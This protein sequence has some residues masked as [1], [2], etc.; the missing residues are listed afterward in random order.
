MQSPSLFISYSHEDEALLKEFT[1]HLSPLVNNQIITAWHDRE[2]VVGDSLDDELRSRLESA[3]LVAFLV[4]SSFLQS[5][6]CYQNE[7]LKVLIRRRTERVEILPIIL[8]DCLWKATP[9][10]QFVAA[11]TDGRPVTASPDRDA[12]WVDVVQQVQVR[13]DRWK[14]ATLMAPRTAADAAKH[15]LRAD[16]QEWLTRT[17]VPFQHKMKQS[18][19]L[20][21]LYVYPDLRGDDV[22]P[23]V[24]FETINSA[25][26]MKPEFVGDG[27]VIHG[28]E[29]AGKTSLIKRL[30]SHYKSQQF[31]PL[32]ADA[33]S[34][35]SSDLQRALHRSVSEQ[36]HELRWDDYVEQQGARILFIDNYDRLRLNVR[37]EKRFLLEA[38]R[39][40]AHLLLVGDSCLTFDEKR[41]VE[42][43]PFRRWE[44]LPFGH[45]RRGELIERWNSLGQEET[46]GDSSLHRRNDETTRNVNSIV[47][48]NLLPPKPVY[49]LTVLQML[50]FVMPSSFELSSYGH[51]YQVLILQALHKVGIRSQDFDP[52]MNYLSELAY[53]CFTIGGE[54]VDEDQFTRFKKE[55]SARFLSRSH[56]DILKTL[57]RAEILRTQGGQLMFSYRYI[58][59]FY[60]AKYLSDH[61]GEV[62]EDV[63]RICESMH[64]ERNA[65]ILIFLMHHSRD[66]RVI[67]E[68]LLRA[69]MIYDG[70][71]PATLDRKETEHILDLLQSVP[72]LV[73]EHIDVEAERKRALDRQDALDGDIED[74]ELEDEELESLDGELADII[75]S[76]RMVEVI[77]QILR[78]R[79]GSLHREQLTELARS[80][81]ETGLRFLS[82]WLDI[83]RRERNGVVALIAEALVKEF[84]RDDEERLRKAALRTYLNLCYGVCRGV[85]G[86]ISNSLGAGELI[87]VFE[88]LGKED[89]DSIAIQLIN[90]VIRMEFTKEIPKKQIE[91]LNRKLD[92]NPVAR[93]L[94]KEVVVHHVY[95]NWVK[96]GD[97]QWISSKL[98]IPMKA[99]RRLEATK[100]A[101]L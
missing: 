4:S 52:Y 51:C 58:F 36:Y 16:F 2:L 24:L 50:D 12:A 8:R 23:E 77:G 33:Q 32:Y 27:V 81:Y 42:L 84:G 93:M 49:V 17:E 40:F 97:K 54:G 71:K 79:S 7:L 82:F 10:V 30:Y 99:Q 90:V 22:D 74:V 46:I 34:I 31:L 95:R 80:G 69:A 60:T 70:G 20:P 64:T 85:I 25:E 41:M 45:A 61:I 14:Q 15:S 21:D 91:S 73:I 75:R 66:Q 53:F 98:G 59:Y 11:P 62:A 47:R 39:I 29:Q 63:E 83:T 78:N 38:R 57:F 65:N 67:D 43:A 94:L 55:Y 68:L 37:Y 88:G 86:K 35:T 9:L 72:D 92:S 48:R 89:P 19:S 87:E 5:T 28:E 13:A 44:M 56:D 3:D 26:L 100:A 1:A 101:K 76:A 18:L 96:V 6:S